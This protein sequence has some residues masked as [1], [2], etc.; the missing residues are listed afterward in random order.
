ML[1]R[2]TVAM[3]RLTTLS[4]M[5]RRGVNVI[6]RHLT[7]NGRRLPPLREL[8]ER[9]LRQVRNT[10]LTSL[11][12]DIPVRLLR[13]R[14]H[15]RLR[16]RARYATTT[17]TLSPYI[18]QRNSLFHLKA[19]LRRTTR[20]LVQFSSLGHRIR[21]TPITL[22]VRPLRNHTALRSIRHRLQYNRPGN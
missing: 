19:R 6:R 11:R 7:I 15:I 22:T 16:V 14:I 21:K 1:T 8:N 12:V 2:K 10:G 9:S 5:K 4:M 3:T 17:T 18:G 13:Q 20:R